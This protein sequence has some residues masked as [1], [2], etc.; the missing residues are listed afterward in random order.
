MLAPTLLNPTP[1]SGDAEPIS[2]ADVP[3]LSADVPF[4]SWTSPD[5]LS[6]WVLVWFTQILWE[7]FSHQLAPEFPY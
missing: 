7:S 3:S 2:I 1:A 6:L 4:C 5:W